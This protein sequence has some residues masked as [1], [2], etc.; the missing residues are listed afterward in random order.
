MES[1]D[2]RPFKS[3]VAMNPFHQKRYLVSAR[4]TTTFSAKLKLET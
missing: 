4:C 3:F 2:L 1:Y